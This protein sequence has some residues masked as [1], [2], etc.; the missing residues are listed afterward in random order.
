MR[1]RQRGMC[2]TFVDADLHEV[3]FS[4]VVIVDD[5]EYAEWTEPAVPYGQI[6][7]I[8][9]DGI[10]SGI[11]RS[12]LLR[13]VADQLLRRRL[14]VAIDQLAEEDHV[15][16][17]ADRGHYAEIEVADDGTG[18]SLQLDDAG[19]VN[20]YAASEA[21]PVESLARQL[22]LRSEWL[23]IADR[24]PLSALNLSARA[25]N[26]A[27]SHGIRTAAELAAYSDKFLMA[28]RNMG[29]KSLEDIRK[30]LAESCASMT[31]SPGRGIPRRCPRTIA[32]KLCLSGKWLDRLRSVSVD[33]LELSNRPRNSLAMAGI[34]ML[35]E[36]VL[37]TQAE[38]LAIDNMGQE[39]LDEILSALR[40][41]IPSKGPYSGIQ[42]EA[43]ADSLDWS[44]P[45]SLFRSHLEKLRAKNRDIELFLRRYGLLGEEAIS[46]A[47]A[48]AMFGIGTMRVG[49]VENGV[50]DK[51]RSSRAQHLLEPLWSA[52]S[53][54]LN[55]CDGTT[56]W[57]CMSKALA[58]RFGWDS[59][60][61]VETAGL[62]KLH[63]AASF[64]KTL[65]LIR[66]PS[67]D[68]A[69]CVKCRERAVN[70]LAAHGGVM[71]ILDFAKRATE[72]EDDARGQSGI[73]GL[74][75]A[76]HLARLSKDIMYE[77]DRVYSA[78]RWKLTQG[79]S[80]RQVTRAALLS[81]GKPIHY[82]DL[83]AHIR[84][85]NKR[86]AHC[87]DIMVYRFLRE[88]PGCV[89]SAPGVFGMSEWGLSQYQTPAKAI[90]DRLRKAGKPLTRAGL[91]A[92]LTAKGFAEQDLVRA[93]DQHS[94]FIQVG[95]GVIDLEERAERQEVAT[96][97]D[98]LM[99]VLDDDDYRSGDETAH[100][101]PDMVAEPCASL[102]L[103][104]ADR[105]SHIERLRSLVCERMNASYK[106]VLFLSILDCVDGEGRA[107]FDAV[108]RHFAGYYCYRRACGLHVEKTGSPLT[109]AV[110]ANSENEVAKIIRQSPLRAFA[111]SG[112]FSVDGERICFD[113]GLWLLLDKPSLRYLAQEARN[114]VEAY[115]S[116]SKRRESED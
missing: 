70:L 42:E 93:M 73:W 109:P 24:I 51:L 25:Y 99:I 46:R 33:W 101:Q 3:I 8:G 19:N 15:L 94:G 110:A 90:A 89:T 14:C 5:Q 9:T 12:S 57:M 53:D 18:L 108:A 47:D 22:G 60:T 26:C 100:R 78:E 44:S 114:A 62:A 58:E 28:I 88:I 31:G 49:G 2:S 67:H 87:N 32:E 69:A 6:H 11:G 55:Q 105:S 74:E 97:A 20:A 75:I 27:K 7:G 71:H 112:L 91:I 72:W 84:K 92:E 39:S 103:A 40:S 17:L 106:P 82:R 85:T 50:L 45:D 80:L 21:F 30:A 23:S 115:F 13:E 41:L 43:A 59:L 68:G 54:R 10:P 1:V 52:M 77:N 83:A 34:E 29:R 63:P 36:L 35:S 76:E 111:E 107:G 98:E 64:D 86:Y 61:L 4:E 66:A 65:S 37:L 95:N 102:A 48:S 113:I 38:L 104:D 56:S 96:T 81:I 116:D 79:R 16:T